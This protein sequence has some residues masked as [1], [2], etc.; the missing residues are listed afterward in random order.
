[1]VGHAGQT[2][3]TVPYAGKNVFAGDAISIK[4]DICIV[5]LPDDESVDEGEC[6]R[7]GVGGLSFD[8]VIPR[9][10][11]DIESHGGLGVGIRAS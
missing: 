11:H 6:E 9:S 10:V 4:L 7:E 2:T 1:M 8:V 3:E 5:R